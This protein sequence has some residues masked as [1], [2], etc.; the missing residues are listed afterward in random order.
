[1]HTDAI[2]PSSNMLARTVVALVSR[3]T[4][5]ATSRARRDTV[6]CCRADRTRRHEIRQAEV[7]NG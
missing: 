5:A 1:M 6:L 4:G 3:D 7:E 2:V